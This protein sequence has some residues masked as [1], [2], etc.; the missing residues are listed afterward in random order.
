[1]ANRGF[2]SLNLRYL[3]Y[4]SRKA[5]RL[6]LG[7]DGDRADKDKGKADKHRVVKDERR[8]SVRVIVPPF[9]D[10]L[11]CCCRFWCPEEGAWPGMVTAWAL[12]RLRVNHERICCVERPVCCAI[13]CS[14]P[15]WGFVR[16][17]SRYPITGTLY[18][19]YAAIAWAMRTLQNR[20]SFG[21]KTAWPLSS[22]YTRKGKVRIEWACRRV[23]NWGGLEDIIFELIDLALYAHL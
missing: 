3:K 14:C 9:A 7:A 17:P 22:C 18:Q 4:A 15:I 20:F 2:P 6:I 13:S 16:P 1:M 21:W 8:P 5:G 19:R 12:V 10:W 23:G 11:T